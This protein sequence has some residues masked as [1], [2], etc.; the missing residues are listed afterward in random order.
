MEISEIDSNPIIDL[1]SLQENDYFYHSDYEFEIDRIFK[2]H[3][4]SKENNKIIC[5]CYA[6]DDYLNY[7]N[8]VTF[9]LNDTLAKKILLIKDE[10]FISSFISMCDIKLKVVKKLDAIKD[11]YD[12]YANKIK[13][14][15]N[16]KRTLKFNKILNEHFTTD[17][18]EIKLNGDLLEFYLKYNDITIENSNN[19]SHLIKSLFV[20]IKF[21]TTNNKFVDYIQGYRGEM[22]IQ[23]LCSSYSHSHL[24]SHTRDFNSF[25]L[26]ASELSIIWDDLRNNNF[27]ENTFDLFLYT[28]NEYVKWESL[29]GGPYTKIEN[30]SYST[31]R[32]V[33]NITIENKQSIINSFISLK[34]PFKVHYNFGINCIEVVN[35]E[36]FIN[37]VTEITPN[38]LKVINVNDTISPIVTQEELKRYASDKL[39]TYHKFK[40]KNETYPKM[41][42]E[43]SFK[44]LTN[45]NNIQAHPE[46]INAVKDHLEKVVNINLLNKFNEKI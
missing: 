38:N 34:K 35:N 28:L 45:L 29:E 20:K 24:S 19:D 30:L 9:H 25:C 27:N 46:L 4:I 42:E 6:N 10:E 8:T 15:D 26:G 33:P 40:F 17:N 31:S 11:D 32:N 22:S 1:N 14:Y 21:N 12:I 39:S 2:I 36:E 37:S 3:T 16:L 44:E 41:Y 43:E 23:E 5:I 13:E 7:D 18:Y